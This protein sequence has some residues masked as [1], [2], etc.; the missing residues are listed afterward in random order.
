MRY[1]QQLNIVLPFVNRYHYN[2]IEII[3]SNIF[4]KYDK[5]NVDYNPN[6]RIFNICTSSKRLIDPFRGRLMKT[7]YERLILYLWCPCAFNVTEA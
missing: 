1:K 5:Y 4:P 2:T 7:S 3:T 6:R